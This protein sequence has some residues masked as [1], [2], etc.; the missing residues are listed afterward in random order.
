MEN[1]SKV[2]FEK[3]QNQE[4]VVVAS[5][6]F[7]ENPESM[8]LNLAANTKCDDFASNLQSKAGQ[9]IGITID[10]SF[11]AEARTTN[12]K[13]L[14]EISKG[15]VIATNGLPNLNA[16]P[17]N[18]FDFISQNSKIVYSLPLPNGSKDSRVLQLFPEGSTGDALGTASS[19]TSSSSSVTA[20]L[21]DS[22]IG[23]REFIDNKMAA[24]SSNQERPTLFLDVIGSSNTPKII[25]NE[26]FR[27]KCPSLSSYW[28]E[29][30]LDNLWVGVRRH[31][32]DKWYTLLRDTRLQFSPWR[33]ER[34]LAE[35]WINE[36]AKLLEKSPS[37]QYQYANPLGILMSPFVPPRPGSMTNFL[38]EPIQVSLGNA[39]MNSQGK[40]PVSAMPPRNRNSAPGNR[41]RQMDRLIGSNK[42]S[43]RQSENSWGRFKSRNDVITPPQFPAHIANS[44]RNDINAAFDHAQSQPQVPVEPLSSKSSH[45]HDKLFKK[46]LDISTR[47][48][49][50]LSNSGSTCACSAVNRSHP[51]Q[52][53]PSDQKKPEVL[54][55]VESDASSEGTISDNSK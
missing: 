12:R 7:S 40:F 41:T 49:I 21:A 6:R 45:F 44:S 36:E 11:A 54:I 43:S 32:K 2:A 37:P 14:L 20:A 52:T 35:K 51:C 26:T 18:D 22:S 25:T 29:E 38:T 1:T 47:N 53:N 55:N 39:Y 16:D 33:T 27:Q 17:P 30:E 19:V 31:G 3:T 15:G 8:D 28:S 50:Y 34:D 10:A 9:F 46:A 24:P 48:G 4:R 42:R 23:T 5:K 13:E